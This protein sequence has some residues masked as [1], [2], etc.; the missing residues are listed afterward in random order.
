[1]TYRNKEALQERVFALPRGLRE[2][3]Y[4][5]RVMA[6]V[7]AQRFNVDPGR[8]DLAVLI[9]DLARAEPPASLL[10]FAREHQWELEQVEEAFP[11]FL[12]GAV[13]AEQAKALGIEDT[14]VLEAAVCHTTGCAGMSDVAMVVFLADKLEP[15]KARRFRGLAPARAWAERDLKRAVLEVLTWLVRYYAGRGDFLHGNM[16]SGRNELLLNTRDI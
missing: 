12:H 6:K 2:H 9:H 1:L 4:R 7:L 15:G 10:A 14:V 5:V 13:G 16:I 8:V 3:I 11:M